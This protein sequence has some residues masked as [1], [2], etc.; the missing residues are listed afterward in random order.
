M[1]DE[2]IEKERSHMTTMTSVTVSGA[3]VVKD[4]RMAVAYDRD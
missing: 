1:E 4:E 2:R 3:N